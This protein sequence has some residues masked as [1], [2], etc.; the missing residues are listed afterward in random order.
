MKQKLEAAK[1]VFHDSDG[2]DKSERG[3]QGLASM[4]PTTY[5][6]SAFHRLGFTLPSDS[7]A[8]VLFTSKCT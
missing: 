8:G 7:T 1:F 6:Y 4:I 2:A 5:F 3:R